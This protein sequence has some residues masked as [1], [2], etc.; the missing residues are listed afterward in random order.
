MCLALKNME[1]IF[2]SNSVIQSL[3]NRVSVRKYTEEEVG[4]ELLTKIIT[5]AKRAPTSSNLQ[6]YSLIVVRD[7][8]RKDKLAELAGNQQHIRDCPVFM[9]VCADSSRV[10]YACETQGTVF[11]PNLESFLIASVDASLFGMA[12]S[13]AAESVG[14][15]SVMIGGIRNHPEQVAKLVNLPNG[16]FALFG[17]CVGWP[18]EHP[19][20]KPRMETELIT[21]HETYD[22]DSVTRLKRY[23]S[24]LA[25]FY[26]KTG[27]NTPDEAWTGI[28][29]KRFSQPRRPNLKPEL[30]NLGFSFV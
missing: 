11:H 27:R 13:L 17:L 28:I 25:E 19:E 24:E 15:G 20:Q 8:A 30:E 22:K 14:L 4:E 3:E 7:Q 21:H 2:R 16:S 9:L 18:E 23:D 1:K 26:K 12:L 29:G 5:S 6:A 10:A